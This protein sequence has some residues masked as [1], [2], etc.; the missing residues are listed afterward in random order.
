MRHVVAAIAPPLALTASLFWSYRAHQT[1]IASLTIA[2]SLLAAGI[3]VLGALNSV[4]RR[5]RISV[6]MRCVIAL[7]AGTIVPLINRLAAL[8]GVQVEATTFWRFWGAVMA[9][10]ACIPTVGRVRDATQIRAR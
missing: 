9:I 7:S 6:A 1:M 10:S 4:C 2:G 5:A 3:A 8:V